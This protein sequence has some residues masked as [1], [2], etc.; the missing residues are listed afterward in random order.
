MTNLNRTHPHPF[1]SNTV[2]SSFLSQS[3]EGSLP[4]SFL[5]P[6]LLLGCWVKSKQRGFFFH[7][8]LLLSFGQGRQAQGRFDMG[9][10]RLFFSRLVY[11]GDC[12]SLSP[13]SPYP[14]GTAFPGRAGPGRDQGRHQGMSQD[15]GVELTTLLG[16]CAFIG[17]WT[18]L[19]IV[20]ED[21]RLSK[22]PLDTEMKLTCYDIPGCR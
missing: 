11:L 1:C 18:F 13:F 22:C 21:W 6:Y 17:S 16:F 7:F 12:E 8:F 10:W 2:E 14:A 4:V 19:S 9:H 5:L 3:L 15:G 20:D